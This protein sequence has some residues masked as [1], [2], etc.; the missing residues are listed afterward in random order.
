MSASRFDELTKR[1]AAA[2][3]RRDMLRMLGLGIAGGALMV[4]APKAVEA[5]PPPSNCCLII[6]PGL[7]QETAICTQG[8]YLDALE[9]TDCEVKQARQTRAC[10]RNCNPSSFK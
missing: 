7:G 1:L 10:G 4:T 9:G 3:S 2:K 8:D 5:A 6:C